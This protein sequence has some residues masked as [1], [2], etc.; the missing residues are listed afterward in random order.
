MDLTDISL[1][2]YDIP[3]T[4]NLNIMIDGIN[5]NHNVSNMDIINLGFNSNNIKN[6]IIEYSGVKY[7]ITEDITN[8]VFNLIEIGVD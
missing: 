5:T 1:Y 3:N 2:F 8:I 7:N 4:I 6:V